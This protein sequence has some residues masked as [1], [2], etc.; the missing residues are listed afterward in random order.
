M[1]LSWTQGECDECGDE[2]KVLDISISSAN[3]CKQCRLLAKFER[4]AY[5]LDLWVGEV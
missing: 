4:I 2:M 1:K 5:A 3:Q